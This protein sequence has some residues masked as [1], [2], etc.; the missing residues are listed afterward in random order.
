MFI[1]FDG[2]DGVGKTT[3]IK[4]VSDVLLAHGISAVRLH[5]WKGGPFEL[6]IGRLS[7]S[8][9]DPFALFTWVLASRCY[10]L[11]RRVLRALR[12][13]ETV[14]L[15][16]YYASSLVYQRMEGIDID[17]IERFLEPFARPDIY[18]QLR[19]P[20]RVVQKRLSLKAEKVGL[21]EI[22]FLC[23]LYDEA[24]DRLRLRG[25]RVCTLTTSALLEETVDEA[26]SI[27][28]RQARNSRRGCADGP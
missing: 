21:A 17:L 16:R 5:E 15:D 6:T 22:R 7:E 10:T 13:G 23:E 11:E 24:F 1:A 26:V 4:S 28:V 27:I 20:V 14:L 19:C 8:E 3:L 12:G 9:H 18:F 25:D 2:P